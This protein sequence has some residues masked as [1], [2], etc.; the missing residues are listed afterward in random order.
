MKLICCV[1]GVIF[2][3]VPLFSATMLPFGPAAGDTNTGINC[4]DC[5][6]PVSMPQSINFFGSV[7]STLYIGSNGL[8]SFE[9]G[10]NSFTPVP[11]P[12]ALHPAICPYWGDWDFRNG[13]SV[14]YRIQTPG[15]SIA[16]SLITSV[17][18]TPFTSTMDIVVTWADGGYYSQHRDKVNTAQVEIH[19][20]G[21]RTFA[22]FNYPP[23]GILW[24]TGDASGG[25]GGFGGTPAQVGF[26]AG[27]NTYV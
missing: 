16:N 15:S 1:F 2:C 20:D 7:W 22:C 27:D 18:G 10:I 11:F 26:D 4:D 5:N 25:S 14:Y 13:G 9:G 12:A 19:S 3:F 6:V 23:N 21:T 17:F 8:V 24:T